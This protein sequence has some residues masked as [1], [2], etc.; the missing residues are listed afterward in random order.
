[1]ADIT[2]IWQIL[3]DLMVVH[4]ELQDLRNR[5]GVV[6]RQKHLFALVA[7]EALLLVGQEILQEVGRHAR[8]GRQLPFDFHCTK[9]TA[10]T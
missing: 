6:L 4:G 8:H 3:H 1:M 10:K 2:V 9:T 7:L 5:K